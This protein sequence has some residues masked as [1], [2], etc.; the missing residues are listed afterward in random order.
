MFNWVRVNNTNKSFDIADPKRVFNSIDF[1]KLLKFYRI[2][3]WNFLVKERMNR[4]MLLSS[5]MVKRELR[6]RNDKRNFS[7]IINK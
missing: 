2:N 4:K 7:V 3:V 5:A 6:E 1:N